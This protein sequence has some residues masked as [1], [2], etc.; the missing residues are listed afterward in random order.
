[1]ENIISSTFDTW[2]T[3]KWLSAMV[4]LRR[5]FTSLHS[6][7]SVI[8]VAAALLLCAL[9]S[10]LAASPI[11][12][13]DALIRTSSVVVNPTAVPVAVDPVLH[14]A[15]PP[16]ESISRASDPAPVGNELS[17]AGAPQSAAAPSNPSA[18][19]RPDQLARATTLREVLHSIVTLHSSDPKPAVGRKPGQ[20]RFSPNFAE[21]ISEDD[22]GIDLR[23]L[24]LDSE[25]AGAML[26]A[27]VDIKSADSHGAT[28]SILGLGNFA[29][30][31]APDLHAAIVSELSSGM[32]FRMSLNGEGFGYDGYPRA[33][34]NGG[35]LAGMPHEHVNL[36]RV[37]WQ[38]F[39]DFLYSPVGALLSMSA[40]IT[41]LL[42]ICVKS[43]VFL[44]R[45]ASRYE[46]M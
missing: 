27:I 44:Q 38:W 30:D 19:A 26:R 28:F 3:L 39:L 31:V 1:M 33:T 45:R 8:A 41:L 36:I 6:S 40:A 2:R 46:H 42:W 17:A 20:G 9:P 10:E 13:L 16:S 15:A 23:K 34:V 24:I 5:T 32:A 21:D 18:V 22:P 37:A 29:L 43:V 35:A 12:S 7:A 11:S 14:P 25:V 4:R